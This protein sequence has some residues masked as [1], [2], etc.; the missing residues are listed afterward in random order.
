MGERESRSGARSRPIYVGI[1]IDAPLERVW[2]LTQDTALHPRW[3]L[4]F[5]SITPVAGLA[6]GC[7]RNRVF[8]FLFGYRV[9]HLRVPERDGCP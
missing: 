4:R 1:L 8:G 7:G 5:S 9:V 2:Q 3:D 6:G